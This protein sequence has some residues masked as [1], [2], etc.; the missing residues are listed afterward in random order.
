MLDLMIPTFNL[1]ENHR[2]LRDKLDRVAIPICLAKCY[3]NKGG[4]QPD[5][6][7]TSS[8]GWVGAVSSS[9]VTSGGGEVEIVHPS[10]DCFL[11]P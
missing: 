9:S 11:M 7:L 6:I 10:F 3:L 1:V 2:V 4:R 5:K 8:S